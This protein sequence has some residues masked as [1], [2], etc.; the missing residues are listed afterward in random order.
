M[1][2]NC[3]RR[4]SLPPRGRQSI[5]KCPQQSK[6]DTNVSLLFGVLAR[7]NAKVAHP[8]G[9]DSVGIGG[10]CSDMLGDKMPGDHRASAGRDSGGENWLRRVHSH[11]LVQHGRQ[12]GQV[13]HR[14]E[15]DILLPREP[16]ADFV[17]QAMQYVL[18]ASKEIKAAG[19]CGRRG[20]GAGHDDQVGVGID[21]SEAHFFLG[22]VVSQDDVEKIV[23]VGARAQAAIDF[24][25]TQFLMVVE[26]LHQ[27]G[28]Q[29]A[30]ENTVEPGELLHAP[31]DGHAAHRLE[32]QR[33][34]RVI[35][36]LL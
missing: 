22:A 16:G 2:R 18:V 23:S 21:F 8:S 14:L 13:H 9:K 12:I 28:G 11:T 30:L 25:D 32:D 33:D 5:D 36:A 31:H 15:R 10:E 6:I 29:Q 17:P 24:F 7:R 3:P 27:R 4:G 1:D 20:L 34:P 35:F 19:H 26:L